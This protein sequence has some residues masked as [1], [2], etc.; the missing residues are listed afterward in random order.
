MESPLFHHTMLP[1][2]FLL[3]HSFDNFDLSFDLKKTHLHILSI[4]TIETI[5]LFFLCD[6]H[7]T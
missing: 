6:L 5:F 2:K 7:V 3:K 1:L 4:Y